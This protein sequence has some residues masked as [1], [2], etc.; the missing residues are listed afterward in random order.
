MRLWAERLHSIS[1]LT[2]AIHWEKERMPA[3]SQSRT[4]LSVARHKAVTYHAVGGAPAGAPARCEPAELSGV[5]GDG[6]HPPAPP[7]LF[8]F[9]QAF[10]MANA[11]AL[12]R[13]GEALAAAGHG[14]PAALPDWRARVFGSVTV[15]HL[16]LFPLL[17]R[18]G[19]H[20]NT[21]ST[22]TTHRAGW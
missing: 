13:L 4:L 15:Q 9:A 1:S 12:D 19:R 10:R 20:C 6:L 2:S 7:R 22:L 3:E 11:A 8:G 18:H 5:E 16:V 21:G 17:P 14:L